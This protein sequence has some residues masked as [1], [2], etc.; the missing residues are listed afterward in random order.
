MRRRMLVRMAWVGVLGLLVPA[1]VHADLFET[2]LRAVRTD[3]GR[4]D[5]SGVTIRGGAGLTSGLS[6]SSATLLRGQAQVGGP[7]GS[8]D[9]ATSLT[10]A[11]DELPALFE[12]LVGNILSSVPMLALCY[13]SPTLCD[14]AKHWQALVN[15]AIQE[16]VAEL[17]GL[18]ST[19]TMQ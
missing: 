3:V 16:T 13:A 10:Q 15:M 19:C 4:A 18:A 1:A 14:L 17:P 11:F 7:C 2:A 6:P 9:F 12:S 8:F 5:M